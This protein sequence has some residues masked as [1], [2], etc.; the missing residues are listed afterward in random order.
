MYCDF[1]TNAPELR[2]WREDMS[3]PPARYSASCRLSPKR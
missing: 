2:S 3:C 1:V